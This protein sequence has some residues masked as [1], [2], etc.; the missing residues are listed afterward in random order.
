MRRYP[1]RWNKTFTKLGFRRTR[2]NE[3]RRPGLMGRSLL[4]EPLEARQLLTVT[5]FVDGALTVTAEV[6]TDEIVLTANVA[7]EVT[8]DLH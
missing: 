4:F 7:G 8:N 6:G 1:S 3:S 2:R 5:S